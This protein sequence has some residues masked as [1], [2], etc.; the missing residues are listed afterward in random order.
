MS[1]SSAFSFPFSPFLIMLSA[2]QLQPPNGGRYLEVNYGAGGFQGTG[3]SR[4]AGLMAVCLWVRNQELRACITLR[5]A[6]NGK[7][8]TVN[9]NE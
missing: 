2:G 3:R 4:L 1:P 9:L 6:E 7:L 8:V 5:R